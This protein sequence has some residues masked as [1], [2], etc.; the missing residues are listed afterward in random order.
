MADSFVNPTGLGTIR[1]WVKNRITSQTATLTI[2]GWSNKQQ[3][4]NVT[5]VTS[6]NNVIVS[7]APTSL[8]DYADALVYCSAQGSGTLTFTCD[9]VPSSAITVNVMIVE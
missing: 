9:T 6:T 2:A 5:G 8:S 7:P 4:V 3:T 1:D